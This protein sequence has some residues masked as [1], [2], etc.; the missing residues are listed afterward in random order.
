MS[1]SASPSDFGAVRRPAG[2]PASLSHSQR[3]W[4]GR[5]YQH[6]FGTAEARSTHI[7]LLTHTLLFAAACVVIAARGEA[8]LQQHTPILT[9]QQSQ[10][11][12]SLPL[13]PPGMPGAPY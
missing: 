12:A 5:M 7:A 10:Q 6:Y 2:G 8:V 1:H 9:Q 4:L 13:Q 3:G 11:A